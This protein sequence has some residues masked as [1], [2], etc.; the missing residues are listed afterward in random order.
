MQDDHIWGWSF[1]RMSE[2]FSMT[3]LVMHARNLLTVFIISGFGMSITDRN[4]MNS[5]C[6]EFLT[7]KLTLYHWYSKNHRLRQYE[8][9]L[10]V[11]MSLIWILLCLGQP[12][13]S[14]LPSDLSHMGSNQRSN[15]WLQWCNQAKFSEIDGL[16][17]ISIWKLMDSSTFVC[18]RELMA[19]QQLCFEN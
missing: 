11:N 12:N 2:I 7:A 18:F 19:S 6:L 1:S 9:G 8:P 16:M 14:Y 13:Y 15:L 3:N 17:Q 10:S 5:A 4:E